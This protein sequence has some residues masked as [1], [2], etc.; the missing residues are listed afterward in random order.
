MNTV[1]LRYAD[2]RGAN[3]MYCDLRGA[4]LTKVLVDGKTLLGGADLRGAKVSY[5][6][7]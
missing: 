7:S 6:L 1:S 4:N 3:L 2:L 5:R